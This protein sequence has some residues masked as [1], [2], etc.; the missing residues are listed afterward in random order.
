MHGGPI[1]EMALHYCDFGVDVR[2]KIGVSRF[3]YNA[4]AVASGAKVRRNHNINNV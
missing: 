1:I 2:S 3:C 4:Y